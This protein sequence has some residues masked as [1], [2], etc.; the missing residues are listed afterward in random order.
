[1]VGQIQQ[2][3]NN[4]NISIPSRDIPNNTNN[5]I[6]DTEI[7]PNYIPKQCNNDYIKKV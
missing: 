7:K 1:M 6:Q 3:S 4:S 5:I 2:I